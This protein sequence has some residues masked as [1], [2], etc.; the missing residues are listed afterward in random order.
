MMMISFLFVSNVR[1]MER[2][3]EPLKRYV[4]S[5]ANDL[6]KCKNERRFALEIRIPFS[7]HKFCYRLFCSIFLLTD[8]N[9]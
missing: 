6:E 1:Q 9:H 5:I 7:F 4:E 2:V 3:D 8:F